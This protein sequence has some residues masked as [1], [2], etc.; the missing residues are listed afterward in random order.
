MTMRVQ[1]S[2]EASRA[3]IVYKSIDPNS[4]DKHSSKQAR[5]TGVRAPCPPG[6]RK[7]AQTRLEPM[8]QDHLDRLE[9]PT[10]VGRPPSRS[11]RRE[12]RIGEMKHIGDQLHILPSQR[13][14]SPFDRTQDSSCSCSESLENLSSS[15][16]LDD[17]LER[18]RTFRDGHLELGGK[19]G[20]AILV[21]LGLRVSSE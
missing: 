10:P 21:V 4:L 12:K 15:G 8:V 14:H 19:V 16:G 7:H 13:D 1:P 18:D 20:K 17:F 11:F 3:C 6:S 9:S 2:H 5:S